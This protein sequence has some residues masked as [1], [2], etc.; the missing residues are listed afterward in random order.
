MTVMMS[1][2]YSLLNTNT[3]PEKLGTASPLQ[4]SWKKSHMH[5]M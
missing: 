2:F 1:D 3:A 5:E 4:P